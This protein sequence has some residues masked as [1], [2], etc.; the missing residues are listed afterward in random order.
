MRLDGNESNTMKIVLVII[1]VACFF[2]CETEKETDSVIQKRPSAL[3][4]G[5]V[6]KKD[7]KKYLVGGEDSTWH[8]GH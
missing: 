2:S 5:K 6:F 4:N 1:F 7:G 8:G 3:E